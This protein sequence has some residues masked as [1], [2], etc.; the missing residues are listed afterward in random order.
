M[1]QPHVRKGSIWLAVIVLL[2]LP[3][4]NLAYGQYA[5]ISNQMDTKS[6]FDWFVSISGYDKIQTGGEFKNVQ[7]DK[8]LKEGFLWGKVKCKFTRIGRF[9]KGDPTANIAFLKIDYF[10]ES[11]EVSCD[12]GEYLTSPGRLFDPTHCSIPVNSSQFTT[13]EHSLRISK[14]DDPYAKL[15][16]NLFCRTKNKFP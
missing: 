12:D 7:I 3:Y 4:C 8:L 9:H 16:I 5:D 6:P 1:I 2:A 13:D 11:I 15:T 10:A 14:S